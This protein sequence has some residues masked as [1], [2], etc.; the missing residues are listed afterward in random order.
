MI[1]VIDHEAKT[2]LSF[3]SVCKYD[4][5]VYILIDLHISEFLNSLKSPDVPNHELNLKAETPVMLLRI[6]DHSS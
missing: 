5:S 3:D 6:I 2:Y 1:S 4:T